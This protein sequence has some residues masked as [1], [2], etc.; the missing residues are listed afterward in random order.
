MRVG[1]QDVERV[2]TLPAPDRDDR[3]ALAPRLSK[4][5]ALEPSSTSI[6]ETSLS[7][8]RTTGLAGDRRSRP[9]PSLGTHAYT[10][11]GLPSSICI[12]TDLSLSKPQ[13]RI[14]ILSRHINCQSG[15]S[16]KR[17]NRYRAKRRPT[18]IQKWHKL[19]PDE[20][21][22]WLTNHSGL[23]YT[24]SKNDTDV[25]HYN[26]D[27]DQPILIIFGRHVAE[28]VCHKTLICYPTSPD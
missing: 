12:L 7:L 11:T 22:N 5:T 6:S 13:T 25:A 15:N 14:N 28:R 3:P 16:R 20:L 1:E 27:A 19:W 2:G 23:S 4:S 17:S 21:T 9:L 26:F 24:V 18:K 8:S 10:A